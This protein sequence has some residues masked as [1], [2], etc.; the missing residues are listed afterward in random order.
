MLWTS[1][2]GTELIPAD[3]DVLAVYTAITGYNPADPNTDQGANEL[4]VLNYWRNNGILGHK[5]TAFV[6]V[7]HDKLDHIRAAINLFGGVYA[8]VR[9]PDSAMDAF[10]HGQMWSDISQTATDGHAIPLVGYDA[11]GFSAITWGRKVYIT[12]LWAAK[13]FDESYAVLSP[14]WIQPVGV[15]PSGFG[16]AQLMTDLSLITG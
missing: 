5:I 11:D 1:L 10:D 8:G 9:L 15:A 7:E 14:D 4:D 6:Q 16:E 12:N 13:Y 3:A 2:A